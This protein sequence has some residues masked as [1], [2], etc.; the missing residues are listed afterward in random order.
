MKKPILIQ[1]LENKLNIELILLRYTYKYSFQKG[2]QIENEKI[3]G[4]NL[5]N[6][7]LT[8]IDFLD[9]FRDLKYLNL[10][11]NNIV[12]IN[13][14][15]NLTNLRDLSIWRNQIDD[16]NGLCLEKLQTINIFQNKLKDVN[17]KNGMS[18]LISFDASSNN[19]HSF[20]FINLNK[21]K[22]L[23]LNWNDVKV[24][25]NTVFGENLEELSLSGNKI[26][27]EDVYVFKKLK[28]LD[29][30]GN[31][32][33]NVDRLNELKEIEELDLGNNEIFNADSISELKNITKLKISHNFLT[34][35]RF[36]EN[37][38]NLK[39]IEIYSNKISKLPNLSKLKNL[40][41]LNLQ[42]NLIENDIQGIN[43]LSKLTNVQLS[44]NRINRI[45][46]LNLKSLKKLYLYN[47]NISFIEN[48]NPK[49]KYHYHTD[50]RYNGVLLGN[51]PLDNSLI[52][53]LKIE[54]N[55]EKQ[56]QLDDYFSN[57]ELGSAPLLEAKLMILGEG[58][59]GKTN[60]RNYIIENSFQIGKSA[61][62]GINIDT[63]KQNINDKDYRINI[64]DFGGQWI[65]QQ[66]HQFFLTNESVYIVLLNARQDEKPEKWLDWIKNYTKDSKVFV[67]ANKMDENPNFS[68]QENLLKTEYPF[69]VGFHY[70]S[71]LNS[72]KCGG[73]EK[74]KVERLLEDVKN[75]ITELK[76]I[77][78]LVPKNYHDLKN[79]LE[80]NFF[81]DAHSISFDVFKNNLFNKHKIIGNPEN[82]LNLLEKIG[83]IRFFKNFD[84]LILSPEWLSDGVYKILM[85]EVASDNN[86]VLDEEIIKKI[87][88]IDSEEKFKYRESDIPFI[89]KLMEDFKLAYIKEN[90]YFIPS[91]F[92][93]DLPLQINFD[94]IEKDYSFK[95][96]F[97]FDTYF[98]EILISKFIVDF[99]EKVYE[100][101]FWKTGILIKDY[102]KD[103][104]VETFAF[105][106][107]REKE[108]R[109]FIHLK[110]ENIRNL[111]KDIHQNIIKYLERTDY[112]FKEYIVYKDKN[113]PLNYRDL[114]VLYQNGVI[115]KQE[116]IGD[117]VIEINVKETLGLINN[118][119]EL[120]KL[121]R[122]NENL[123]K[124][125]QNIEIIMGNKM[126]FNNPKFGNNN[127]I[128]TED[129]VQNIYVNKYTN[130]KNIEEVKKIIKEFNQLKVDNDD[131][132][133]IFMEGMSDLIKLQEANDE[134]EEEKV[135]SG[136][137]KFYDYAKEF[138]IIKNIGFLPIDIYEKGEKML[139]TIHRILY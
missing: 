90:K 42:N 109:I 21:I 63:W 35:I 92:Q 17:F 8:N 32:L 88:I 89:K 4:L 53:I 47:N 44:H 119:K 107:S 138:V 19:I 124:M 66:V 77:N 65:Q 25:N 121:R 60:L 108:R 79:D 7:N 39:K 24:F 51:N 52:E 6:L 96:Y 127:Q 132:K 61:T 41:Y 49:L 64:W 10:S 110:G 58:E 11:N 43:N 75:Q 20:N 81:T 116:V 27:I 9:D 118:D 126:K 120:E 76:N 111:F 50:N 104:K 46:E 33:I 134:K 48:Y 117:E 40:E 18:N 34:D 130:D 54:N 31:G 87:I 62:T 38:T 71:L 69:I 56:K 22:Y 78:A 106:I 137:Q 83:T 72:N 139:D 12:D 68:L 112:K 16:I 105:V 30:F 113:Y 73:N 14:I 128:G 84:K 55:S 131:W 103:L 91:Q 97:E 100:N 45:P 70:I 85:S 67:V 95:F 122:E 82:L 98:P 74:E 101:D 23:D 123:K 99:F 102:D 114:I 93:T 94:D 26:S 59:S 136:I 125:P 133:R 57:L 28:K 2:Y 29:I 15:N 3:V 135:K 5:S 37:L 115:N 86:G 36:I 1:K 13:P 129:S 80:D